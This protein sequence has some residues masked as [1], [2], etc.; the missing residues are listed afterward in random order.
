MED[1]ES[2][3]KELLLDLDEEMDWDSGLRE[4]PSVDAAAM[5][6][7]PDYVKERLEELLAD[8]IN[9]ENNYVVEGASV[10]CDQM[11]NKP[12]QMYYWD[13]K[14]GIKGEGGSAEI[15]YDLPENGVSL[16]CIELDSNEIEIGRFHAINSKQHA[17]GLRFA[18]I[19][20]R[21]C[22]RDKI[23]KENMKEGKDVAN[24]ISMGNCKIM[25]DS[26]VLEI[27][28]RKGRAKIYGTCYCLMKPDTQWVNPMCMESLMENSDNEQE[29]E[30]QCSHDEHHHTMNWNTEG[31]QEEG[32]TRLSTLLCTRG[33]IITFTWS[34]QEMIS[35][36]EEQ[37]TGFQFTLEQLKACGWRKVSEEDLRKLNN[38]MTRFG[39]TSRESAYMML[40]TMLV[41]S[42]NCTVKFEGGDKLLNAIKNNTIEEVWKKYK[43]NVIAN[44]NTIGDYEW[45][46]RGAG[47]IQLTGREEQERFLADMG[48]S[49]AEKDKATYIGNNYPIEA[50]VWY[51][52]NVGKT[53]EGNLNAYVEKNGASEGMFLVTQYFVN[54]YVDGIDDTLRSI[55]EGG[56]YTTNLNQN[57]LSANGKEFPLPNG[58]EERSSKWQDVEEQMKNGG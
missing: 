18:T 10:T 25:R 47:Y 52:T 54:G 51:W 44:G 31:G 4:C 17:N 9:D 35:I 43:A 33:G 30:E 26:D 37:T 8:Y 48:D 19:S 41:E 24:L 45:W 15:N 42:E 57:K 5:T 2:K 1:I 32:L 23:E 36:E 49:F 34:G 11:S 39:V 56:S 55:K 40:A 12:V 28:K 14:L 38:A 29:D 6:E 58:W 50:A 53:G 27:N 21:S 3:Q 22:L 7:M 20:D 13:G 46:E 16:P